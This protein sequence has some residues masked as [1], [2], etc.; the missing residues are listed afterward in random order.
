VSRGRTLVAAGLLAASL[1]AAGCAGDDDIEASVANPAES[2]GASGTNE[3]PDGSKTSND[4]DSSGGSGSSGGATATPTTGSPGESPL[5]KVKVRDLAS[6]QLV[7]L[8]TLLPG[9]KP[10][11]IWFW[12]PY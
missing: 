7:D 1:L 12:A 10:L 11:A 8:S 4:N 5:P 9:D 6:G 2:S 3:A